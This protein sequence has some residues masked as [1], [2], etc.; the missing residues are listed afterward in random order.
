[1]R[2]RTIVRVGLLLP[3]S[4]RPQDAAALY[5]AAELALFDHGNQNTLL[6]P[7]DAGAD[8]TSAAAAARALLTDGAD[9]IIGGGAIL[10][11]LMD[12]IAVETGTDPVALGILVVYFI[13]GALIYALYG[14]R[15]SRLGRGEGP[16]K[17][18]P[19]EPPGD[20]LTP[21]GTHT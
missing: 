20:P 7:R 3:F 9:I 5:S 2:G 18:P 13:I 19:A 1:M 17:G 15:N 16:P 12:D 8:E 6:I 10:E 14:Y 21:S 11:T 4:L